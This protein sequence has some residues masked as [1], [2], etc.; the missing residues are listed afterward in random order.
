MTL[1]TDAAIATTRALASELGIACEPVVVADRSNLVLRLDPHPLV[2][3]VAMATSLARV[4]MEWLRR[5]VEVARFL[6]ERGALV[7][8]PAT[9]L[10]PGPHARDGFTLSF[11]ELEPLL[12][13]PVDPG[14]AGRSLAAAH[15][16]LAAYPRAKLPLWGGVE[17]ARAVHAR[18]LARGVFD[19]SDRTRLARAW[20]RA[21]ELVATA[22]SRTANMQAVHGDAHLGN[23]LASVRGAVW[24]DWEDAFV[25]PVEW[26]L[27]SLRSRAEL[28]GEDAEAIARASE[29]YDAPFD[30][31]LARELGLVR[32]LQVIPW[33]ALFAERQPEL[34]PRMRAR[35]AKLGL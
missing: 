18:A 24:T 34:I 20:E 26:D 25:G 21:E 3:R 1:S 28:F 27:A 17:E 2:A 11:W 23:V 31:E 22:P 15:R 33:L 30:P 13:T 8:R 6:G 4:G 19:E 10:D 32:N 12:D 9:T 7:T 29:A 14:A 35:L 16:A 5:E